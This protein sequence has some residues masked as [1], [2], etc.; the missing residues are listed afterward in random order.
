MNNRSIH[1]IHIIPHKSGG[2][3]ETL[4]NQLVSKGS[5]IGQGCEICHT[6]VFAKDNMNRLLTLY[7]LIRI[8][9]NEYKKIK[10]S[11]NNTQVILHAH[12][13]LGIY[14]AWFVSFF[15]DIKLVLTEHNTTNKRRML[16]FWPMEY[17]I[18]RRFNLLLCISKSVLN[19]LYKWLIFIPKEKFVLIYNGSR[20]LGMKNPVKPSNERNLNLLSIGSLT[21]QKGFDISLKYL[22]ENTSIPFSYKILGQGPMHSRLTT[23]ADKYSDRGSQQCE[24]VGYVE[25]IIPYLTWADILIVPSRWEGFGL[26]VIEALSTGTPVVCSNVDGMNEI[27]QVNLAFSLFD[28]NNCDSLWSAIVKTSQSLKE[29]PDEVK[30]ECAE[31]AKRFTIEKM[32][33]KYN[34]VYVEL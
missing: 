28:L 22:S 14:A 8:T 18:Y 5:C 13:T 24:L 6:S 10:T 3:A 34:S 9:L 4:V 20:Y 32:I 30:K 11:V 21:H 29:S 26:V 12:L 33:D 2:G 25:D 7:F 19:S 31:I 23:L 15:I 1:I 17:L 16:V 27:S